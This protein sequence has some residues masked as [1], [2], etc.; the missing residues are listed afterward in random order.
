[1]VGGLYCLYCKAPLESRGARCRVCGW[2]STYGPRTRRQELVRGV[3][4]VVVTLVMAV[5]FTAF[6]VEMVRP[7]L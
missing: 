5:A 6:V 1:M 7:N 4:I 3:S 2:A